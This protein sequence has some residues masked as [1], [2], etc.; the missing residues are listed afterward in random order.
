MKYENKFELKIYGESALFTDPATKTGGERLTYP[1]PTYE[2]VKG[3]LESIYRQPDM[4]WVIDKIRIMNV[5][6]TFSRG[7][8]P[9]RYGGGRSLFSLTFLR[10]PEY[11]ITAHFVTSGTESDENRHYFI[12]KRSLMS[13]G[14]RDVFLGVRSCQ[15]YAE[16]CEFGSGKGFYD[17]SG[18]VK[19]GI[20]FHSF[21]Y[22]D[23][24]A[25]GKFLVRLWDAHMIDGI[26]AFPPP[27][28]CTLVN[29]I[30]DTKESEV[31]R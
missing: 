18:A 17:N 21:L 29:D 9:L 4:H 1:V 5:I 20:M 6:S 11:Q 24:S 28:D 14:R 31:R 16:P 19:L 8:S 22:P 26:I 12:A 7:Y 3:M 30:T 13:G 25:D 23:K 10:A 27:E 15:G 2:A